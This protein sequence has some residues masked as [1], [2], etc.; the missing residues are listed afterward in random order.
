VSEK[1]WWK[2][3]LVKVKVWDKVSQATRV[4]SNVEGLAQEVLKVGKNPGVHSWF[5][6]GV[7]AASKAISWAKLNPGRDPNFKGCLVH[8][9]QQFIKEF[10][11]AHEN[12]KRHGAVYVTELYGEVIVHDITDPDEFVVFRLVQEGRDFDSAQAAIARA[13]W[14]H[15]GVRLEMIPNKKKG[16]FSVRAWERE[17]TYESVQTEEVLARIR[18]FMGGGESR[19]VLLHGP[20]GTGKTEMARRMVHTMQCHTLFVSASDIHSCTLSHVLRFL[21]P[22]AVVIDDLDLVDDVMSLL[23]LLDD[24]KGSVRLFVATANVLTNFDSA[25]LRPGRFDDIIQVDRVLHPTDILPSWVPQE[26]LDEVDEWPVSFLKEL[27]IRLRNIGREALAEEMAD[28]R[29]RVAA[30]EAY[31][32]RSGFFN[33]PRKKEYLPDEVVDTPMGEKS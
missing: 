22:T 16:N 9:M 8:F 2:D 14:E 4:L 13:V 32:R 10:C 20:P 3:P 28:L 31:R 11:M 25:V 26:V 19:N 29:K 17:K 1:P 23:D 6:L 18:R 15:Y 27:D 21:R 24:L 7:V 30:N 12:T 33:G 5:G